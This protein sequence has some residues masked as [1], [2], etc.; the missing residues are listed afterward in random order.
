M[1]ETPMLRRSRKMRIGLIVAAVCMIFL[2]VAS[3]HAAEF[4]VKSGDDIVEAMRKARSGDELVMADGS[5]KADEIIFAGKGAPD[6]PITL[7][8]RTP[9][10]VT[11]DDGS[12]L[13]IDGEHLVVSGLLFIDSRGTEKLVEIKGSDTRFTESAIIALNR[14]GRFVHFNGGRRNRLD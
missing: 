7:R 12:T 6:K 9:G 8:A 5:W 11:M 14:G 4:R 3:A 10:K 13:V 2:A 1:G